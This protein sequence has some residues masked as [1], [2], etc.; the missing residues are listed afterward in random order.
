MRE[1]VRLNR[2]SM[3]LQSE[4]KP[5]FEEWVLSGEGMIPWVISK[6]P[7]DIEG[8]FEFLLNNEKGENLPQGWV[9]DSTYWVRNS[10]FRETERVC[11]SNIGVFCK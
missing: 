3:D 7:E 8:M 9:P 2:P 6:N 1:G 11:N 5:F 4:Y 10:S